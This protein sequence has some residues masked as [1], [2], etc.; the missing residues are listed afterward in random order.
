MVKRLV[1]VVSAETHRRDI[2]VM[3]LA[4]TRGRLPRPGGLTAVAGVLDVQQGGFNIELGC[5]VA[6]IDVLNLHEGSAVITM[7]ASKLELARGLM[8]VVGRSGSSNQTYPTI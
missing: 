5:L 6:S 1:K 3:W 4:L 2:I 7:R 8:C